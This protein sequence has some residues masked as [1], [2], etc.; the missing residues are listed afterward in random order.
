MLSESFCLQLEAFT[1]LTQ[2]F[3][4]INKGFERTKCSNFASNKDTEEIWTFKRNH[5]NCL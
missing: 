4:P 1:V 3:K 2:S 5:K